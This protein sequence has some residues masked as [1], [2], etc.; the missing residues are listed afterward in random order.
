MSDFITYEKKVPR[1]IESK[2]EGPSPCYIEVH[3]NKV[4]A[5]LKVLRREEFTVARRLLSDSL[6]DFRGALSVS[7]YPLAA[8]TVDEMVTD[9]NLCQSVEDIETVLTERQIKGVIVQADAEFRRREH[10]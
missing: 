5:M 7:G 4:I 9:V 2:E 3:A 8:S 6:K 1:K 10:R